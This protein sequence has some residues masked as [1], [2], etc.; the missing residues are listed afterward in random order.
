MHQS[1]MR[2]TNEVRNSDEMKQPGVTN[3]A[4]ED[5]KFLLFV[6]IFDDIKF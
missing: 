5:M 1:G 4:T 3:P 6:I 2:L